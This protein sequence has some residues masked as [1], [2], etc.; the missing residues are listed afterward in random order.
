MNNNTILNNRWKYTDERLKKYLKL[1]KKTSLK[2][3]D[4]LQNILNS[5]N[6]NY[7]DLNKPISKQQKDRFNRMTDEWQKLGLLTGYFGYMVNTLLTKTKIT[8]EE[9][10]DILIYSE[11]V[12]ERKVLDEYE[13]ILFTEIGNDLYQQG[14]TE[15]KPKKKKNYSLT[16]DFIWGLLLLSNSKGYK[17]TDYTQ[18][19]A[20]S[21]AD[22]IKRQVIINLQQ[23]K[24]LNIDDN[25]LKHIVKKQQNQY[26]CIN[27]DK[28]SG[29]LD[30]QV[31]EIANQSF[32]KAGQDVGDKNLQARF[33][34]EMDKRTT[35][36]CKSMDNILFYVNDWNTFQRYSDEDGRIVNYKV[37]GL[38]LGVNL[39]PITN[40]F[41]YCRSTITYLTDMPRKELNKKLQTWTERAKLKDWVSSDF[42]PINEKMYKGLPLTNKD[43]KSI[44]TLYRALNKQP[45]YK[46]K[47]DEMIVRVLELDNDTINS[48]IE[49]HQVGKVYKSKAFE[50]YSLKDGYNP[51]ANVYFYVQNSK[52][53]R[54]MLEYNPIEKEA[55]VLYQYGTKFV[56]KEYYKIKDKHYFLLEEL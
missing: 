32:I 23:N 28:Y 41:H 6:Y 26:L 54:N 38:V 44:K 46:A 10:L 13:K 25:S 39:P 36:M 45:Y 29:A 4:K 15:I 21:N 9:L 24:D 31:V 34:A 11:Y 43:R 3:Q 33:I 5:V 30:S 53:A 7:S 40:H 47:D 35:E 18:T 8:N 51:N 49:Q 37:F 14:I 1:Y 2:T 48:V 56:T 20:R 19:L 50:S 27:G 22:N 12:K 17:W 42:Y 55:E 16:W 52:K